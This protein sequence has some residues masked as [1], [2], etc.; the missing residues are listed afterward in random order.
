MTATVLAT[1]IVSLT[2]P[3]PVGMRLSAEPVAHEKQKT[4]DP[5]FERGSTVRDIPHENRG[6]ASDG[7]GPALP[8]GLAGPWVGVDNEDDAILFEPR[9]VIQREL[10]RLTFYPVR[11]ADNNFV[12]SPKQYPFHIAFKLKGDRLELTSKN[13]L[14]GERHTRY[15]RARHVPAS[16]Q[17]KPMYVAKQ[18]KLKDA[19]VETIR[20][21]LLWRRARDKEIRERGNMDEQVQW[22]MVDLQVANADRMKIWLQ[23]V[24][25]IDVKRFGLE[26]SRG[27]F[28]LVQHS[29]DLPLM[30]AVL[31]HLE[32]DVKSGLLKPARLYALLYDRIQVFQALQQRYG[33]QV[34]FDAA[35]NP[36]VDDLEDPSQVDALRAKLGMETLKVYLDRFRPRPHR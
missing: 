29:A 17:L 19:Y 16:L 30:L 3:I 13:D 26:V 4:R 8:N 9:R 24:G 6:P 15:R 23:Q 14:A 34:S 25:W 33:T 1:L 27:A 32:R 10:G 18:T 11:Y 7:H 28:Y 2:A 5:H 20:K 22:E 36:V 35:G 31:P 12:I 21:E